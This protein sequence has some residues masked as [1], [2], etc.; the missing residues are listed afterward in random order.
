MVVSSLMAG[1]AFSLELFGHI[2]T[3]IQI[4]YIAIYL[5]LPL[6]LHFA[7]IISK[8]KIKTP[9]IAAC[10]MPALVLNILNVLGYRLYSGFYRVD[11]DLVIIL[12]SGGPVVYFN[13]LTL[14]FYFIMTVAVLSRWGL[15]TKINRE[16]L[17]SKILLVL[18]IV[19]FTGSF[20]MTIYL[21]ITKVYT[22]ESTGFPMFNIYA[23]GLYIII[24]RYRFLN[25]DYRIMADEVISNI[26]DIVILL[27]HDLNIIDSN[28]RFRQL[29]KDCRPDI[30]NCNLYDLVEETGYLEE[31]IQNLSG[32]R[33]YNS[34]IRLSYKSGDEHTVTK[35]YLA[36]MKDKFGD[37]AGYFVISSE[38]RE[39]KQ[40]R[41]N[42]RITRRELEVIELTIAGLT[43]REISARLNIAEKTVEAHLTNIYNKIGINNKIEL[44]R[45]AGDFNI[46]PSAVE[47]SLRTIQ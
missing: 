36:R 7:F 45:I 35:T 27:D 37:D 42:F 43:Y 34:V 39:I 38:I 23:A 33:I 21:P 28:A 25:L 32:N 22:Y 10:Y 3:V 30:R 47:Q 40:F 17:Y 2:F 41:K 18:F 20:I 11:N 8:I 9:V 1:I 13:I 15:S 12:N 16:K 26:N 19:T 44:I 31:V 29:F 46:V 6:N 24:S 5:Y 4:G 14:V